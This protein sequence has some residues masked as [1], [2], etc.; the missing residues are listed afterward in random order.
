MALAEVVSAPSAAV[1]DK[2]P[3]NP[4]TAELFQPA[5]VCSQHSTSQGVVLV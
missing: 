2:E 4:A 1:G 3:E 5:K